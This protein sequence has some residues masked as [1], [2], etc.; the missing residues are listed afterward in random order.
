MSSRAGSSVLVWVEVLHVVVDRTMPIVSILDNQWMLHLGLN[1]VLLVRWLMDEAVLIVWVDSRVLLGVL[2]RIWLDLWVIEGFEIVEVVTVLNDQW[3]LLLFGLLWRK[4]EANL[5]FGLV[6]EF[7]ANWL[8]DLTN[9]DG[10]SLILGSFQLHLG[11]LLLGIGGDGLKTKGGLDAHLVVLKIWFRSLDNRFGGD[12]LDPLLFLLLIELVGSLLLL[13]L[14]QFL[15]L[16]EGFLLF[17]KILI[18]LLGMLDILL[19]GR[20]LL[21]ESIVVFLHLGELL[22]LLFGL[23]E[24]GKLLLF[25]GLESLVDGTLGDIFLHG[26]TLIHV[27]VRLI[28]H[29]GLRF[30]V[31]F[32][33]PLPPILG[34]DFELILVLF[35]VLSQ[36]LL[37]LNIYLL[38][39]YTAKQLVVRFINVLFQVFTLMPV[40]DPDQD[41]NE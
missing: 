23:I 31:A 28:V 19:H 2:M 13:S 37:E 5:I 25:F 38:R 40:L 32:D 35:L 15:L 29:F 27:F 8:V 6:L 21:L 34:V 3:G 33:A 4:H 11:A 26:G 9:V 39:H 24:L 36:L 18:E 16:R 30:G 14:L 10:S 20:D 17:G 22:L 12:L 41:V 7:E 1:R